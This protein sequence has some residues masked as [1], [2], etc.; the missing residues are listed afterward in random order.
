M[1]ISESKCF[2][3]HG[4]CLLLQ[5]ITR[6]LGGRDV[7]GVEVPAG[8]ARLASGTS[9]NQHSWRALRA[10]TPRARAAR[11]SPSHLQKHSDTSRPGKREKFPPYRASRNW[12]LPL[13]RM[14]SEEDKNF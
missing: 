5:S 3:W 11:S 13:G 4:L 8:Q 6:S 1:R 2:S 10:A 9:P 7:Q 14:G 12:D